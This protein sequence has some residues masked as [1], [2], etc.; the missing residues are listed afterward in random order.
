MT[1]LDKPPPP[2][3]RATLAQLKA[4][5]SQQLDES[6]PERVV[7]IGL[8]WNREIWNRVRGAG[9][10]ATYEREGGE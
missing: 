6:D 2:R 1:D 5:R 7:R 4:M 8:A 3:A 9:A 10:T